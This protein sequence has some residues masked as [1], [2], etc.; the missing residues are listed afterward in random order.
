MLSLC[1]LFASLLFVFLD[2]LRS[3]KWKQSLTAFNGYWPLSSATRCF[4]RPSFR[5]AYSQEIQ[6]TAG[7]GL[8]SIH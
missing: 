7:F 1:L 4:F 2:L 6:I 5:P 3:I 8:V